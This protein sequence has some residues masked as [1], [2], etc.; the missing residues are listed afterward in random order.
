MEIPTA[1]RRHGNGTRKIHRTRGNKRANVSRSHRFERLEDRTLLAADLN[2]LPG[3]QNPIRQMDVN[4]DS[5]VTPLDAL[6]II[7]DLNNNGSRALGSG[8]NGGDGGTFLAASDAPPKR[9]IDVNGDGAVTPLDALN[10]IHKLNAAQNEKVSIR[11]EITDINGN[12]VETLSPGQDFQVRVFV[13][14]I[15]QPED[16]PGRGVFSAFADVVFDETLVVTTIDPAVTGPAADITYGPDY[17]SHPRS[18]T[19]I[20]A[21]AGNG[22]LDDVGALAGFDELGSAER[23]LFAAPFRVQAGAAGIAAFSVNFAELIGS[24]VLTF[25]SIEA[26]IPEEEILFIGDAVTIGSLPAASINDVSAFEGST[27]GQTDFTFTVSLSAPAIVA[28]TI[29]YATANPTVGDPAEVPDDYTPVVGGQVSFAVGEQTKTIVIKVNADFLDEP[30]ENFRVLLSQPVGATIVDPEGV[31]T[32]QN[33]D[34]APTLSIDSVTVNEPESGTTQAVFTVTLSNPSLSE[35]RV[36]V[37]TMDDTA[38]DAG[39]DYEPKTEELIFAPGQT[40]RQFSV[41]VNADQQAET[42]EKFKAVLSGA[43]NATIN[44]GTGEATIVDPV[45]PGTQLVKIDVIATDLNG[46]PRTN[47]DVGE[48][49]LIRIFVDDLRPDPTQGVFQAYHDLTYETEFVSL[50]GAGI[51]FGPDYPNGRM[52][53]ITQDGLIDEVGALA[54]FTPLDGT[55]RLLWEGEFIGDI[56]GIADFITDPAE[57]VDHEVLL[58]GSNDAVP[59][60]LVMYD[61][62]R[63]T[64]GEPIIVGPTILID[65]P[66]VVEGNAGTTPMTFTVLLS[67]PSDEPVSVTYTTADITATAGLDYQSQSN[68][69][70]F[71]PG[72]TSRT[73]SINVIGDTLLEPPETFRVVLSN[74]QGGNLVP[75]AGFGTGTILDDEARTISINDAPPAPE[76]ST[77]TFTVTLSA[78]ASLP[79][80]VQFATADGTAIA[81][82]D[83]VAVANTLTFSTGESSKTITVQLLSDGIE[84][85][86]ETFTVNLSNAVGATIADGTGLGTIAVVQPA[87]LS[88]FVYVDSNF[89]GVRNPG[90]M[91]IAGVHVILYGNSPLLGS[92]QMMTQTDATGRYLFSDLPPGQYTVQEIQPAFFQDGLEQIGANGGV[93]QANDWITAVNFAGGEA[94]TGYNFGEFGLRPHFMLKRM[95]L[96]STLTTTGS[97]TFNLASGD[98]WFSFDAGFNQLDISA[99]SHT[100]TPVYLDVYDANLNLIARSPLGQ[101]TSL[102]VAGIPMQ[103]YFLRIGGGSTSVSVSANVFGGPNATGLSPAGFDDAFAATEDW[104]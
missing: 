2:L 31:A 22:E 48:R 26:A 11:T 76:G 36:T 18:E 30:N 70:T 8:V 45:D 63:V 84:E 79:I 41:T 5:H 71:T 23:L 80:T 104:I 86:D 29:D 14:D 82:Q 75:G 83:Y 97:G 16:V 20:I 89:N 38:T 28:T 98:I 57:D 100:G 40:T 44:Q 1:I 102:S 94:A 12:I 62:E 47:F 93:S 69:I 46:V 25:D 96:A 24:E 74:P 60:E 103:A 55:P 91:G 35:V 39:N 92:F 52:A 10:I 90:E 43:V 51:Q 64:I 17:P 81:A 59:P 68:T 33:D 99:V 42:S 101:S 61:R 72:Q 32:I 19:Q 37:T 21:N 87:G 67:E 3:F 49:F 78:P 9:F 27:G 73:I 77:A 95:L 85:P 56:D 58:F 65:N 34:Q 50:S 4:N 15:R 53:D 7:S 54:E 13:K 88:G 66:S 6:I